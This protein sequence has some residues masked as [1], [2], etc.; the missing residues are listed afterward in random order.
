MT[1]IELMVAVLIGAALVAV[2]AISI[3]DMDRVNLRSGTRYVATTIRFA[4]DRSRVTGRDHRL[5]FDL[6]AEGGTT[7]EF[8]IA[9]KGKQLLPRDL[10]E[11]W[12]QHERFAD[13]AEDEEAKQA[14]STT[15]IGGLSKSLLALPRPTG[16]QW[17]KVKLRTKDAQ[18]KLKKAA[19]LVKSIYVARLDKEVEEGK[20]A[21]HIW[22]GGFLERAAFY[23]SDGKG[24]F[25]TLV[26]YPLT[27]RVKIHE[28][29]VAVPSDLLG[30][31][32]TGERIQDR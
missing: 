22:R 12:K 29:R 10:D 16:P 21:V 2:A 11:A 9:T 6:D 32:D 26:T 30:Q 4:F 19:R 25:Y 7:V 17:Q 31:D 27:G 14:A 5:V 23:L 15:T 1:V 8:E 18:E 20:V 24:R 13:G 3:R 28:G